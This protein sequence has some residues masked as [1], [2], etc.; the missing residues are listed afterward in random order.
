MRIEHVRKAMEHFR[1]STDVV[2]R[3]LLDSATR[4]DN[5]DY[6]R[7]RALQAEEALDETNGPPPT[8]PVDEMNAI[9]A[10][11]G[12]PRTC[13]EELERCG[14]RVDG[15]RTLAEVW[16]RGMARRVAL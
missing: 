8:D 11:A 4:E 15:A 5:A 2:E 16:A 9:L 3:L 13:R 12:E 10:D 6:W 1:R 7:R 14:I